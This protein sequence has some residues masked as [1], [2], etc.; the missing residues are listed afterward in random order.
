[1]PNEREAMTLEQVRD[2]MRAL[3]LTLPS[4]ATKTD[5]VVRLERLE[6]VAKKILILT[7]AIDAHL[8][9]A[10]PV[11]WQ[12]RYQGH[13]GAY[14]YG[15]S[16]M[17]TREQALELVNGYLSQNLP[18]EMRAVFTHPSEDPRERYNELLM[19]VHSRFQNESRH[20]TALRYIQERENAILQVGADAAIAKES[21]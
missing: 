5:I 17:Y 4:A 21:E 3:A 20:Q 18:A 11:F 8:R 10:E 2:E 9:A 7:D 15:W 19:A 16:G 6:G 13:S 12:V 14:W 1:M